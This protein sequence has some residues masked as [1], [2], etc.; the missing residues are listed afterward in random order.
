LRGSLWVW[1]PAGFRPSRSRDG[2]A[3]RASFPYFGAS[4]SWD[5]PQSVRR[6]VFGRRRLGGADDRRPGG[7]PWGEGAAGIGLVAAA[8]LPLPSFNAPLRTAE[9][10]PEVDLLWDHARFVLEA[11]CRKHHAIEVAF[12]RDHKRTREL[13]AADYGVLRVTW[14]EAELEAPAVFATLRQELRRRGAQR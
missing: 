11:D 7:S 9:R 12:D 10:I 1:K 14:R 4:T 5:T 3:R 2:S 13:I 8:G 6:R